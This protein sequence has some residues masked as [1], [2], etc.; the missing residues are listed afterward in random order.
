MGDLSEIGNLTVV[1]AGALGSLL[2]IVFQSRCKRICW[3]CITRELEPPKNPPETSTPVI[4]EIEALIP[5][6]ADSRANEP[7]PES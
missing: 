1:I 4:P 3:G 2:L 5:P 6:A 7:E